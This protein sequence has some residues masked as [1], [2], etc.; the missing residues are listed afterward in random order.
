MKWTGKTTAKNTRNGRLWKNIPLLHQGSQVSLDAGRQELE[1][2]P[3]FQRRDNPPFAHGGRRL[4]DD[5]RHLTVP[6]GGQLAAAKKVAVRGV[7]SGRDQDEV[8]LEV[9]QRRAKP[10]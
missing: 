3:A 2:V 5:A 10:L 6:G 1:A 8:R 9:E 7:E 4:L